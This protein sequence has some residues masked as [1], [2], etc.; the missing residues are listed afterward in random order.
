MPQ[1]LDEPKIC[2]RGRIKSDQ[3]QMLSVFGVQQLAHAFKN[4]S[5]DHDNSCPMN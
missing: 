1:Y 2:I 5:G 3:L 4:T